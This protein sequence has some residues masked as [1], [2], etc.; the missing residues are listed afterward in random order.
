MAISPIVRSLSRYS[1]I[2]FLSWEGTHQAATWPCCSRHPHFL[3]CIQKSCSRWPNLAI[4][5]QTSLC[6]ALFP[7]S[8]QSL[9]CLIPAPRRAV[10]PPGAAGA[11]AEYL[12]YE[13]NSEAFPS[14]LSLQSLSPAR[15]PRDQWA[16][17]SQRLVNELKRFCCL[18]GPSQPCRDTGEAHGLLL[19]LFFQPAC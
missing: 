1:S 8:F 10:R 9:L 4:G 19:R 3:T 13:K 18:L 2:W 7:F 14:K 17:N 5:T 11:R 16:K 6:L 12:L 15:P